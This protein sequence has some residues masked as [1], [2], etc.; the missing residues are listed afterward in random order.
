MEIRTTQERPFSFRHYQ[1]HRVG[2]LNTDILDT[3][4]MRDNKRALQ[5]IEERRAEE[6]EALFNRMSRKTGIK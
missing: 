3:Y 2:E 6:I 5:S 4:A 1:H